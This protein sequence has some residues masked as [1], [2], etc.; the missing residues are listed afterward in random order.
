MRKLFTLSLC[1]VSA[2]ALRAQTTRQEVA[3]NSEYDG[4]TYCSYYGGKTKQTAPPEGYEPFYVSHYGRHGSRYM[5]S[6]KPY[7]VLI[8][9]LEKAQREGVLTRLGVQTLKKLRVAYAHS[10][11]KAGELTALGGRQHEGIAE[12]LYKRCPG[13]FTRTSR[14][15]AASTMVHRAQESMQF[16][17]GRLKHL[18]FDMY[19]QQ[20][21]TREDTTFMRA[22][23][24]KPQTG[25]LQKVI[26]KRIDHVCDSLRRTVGI[27][28]KLFTDATFLARN[29][30]DTTRLAVNFYDVSKDMYCLPELHLRF[31]GLFSKTDLF[32]LWQ[33]T[34]YDWIRSNGFIAGMTP[35]YKRNYNL[36]QDIITKAD[37]KMDEGGT[38]ASLRFGH[39]S[40]LVP[41]AYMLQL[42]GS[43]NF[44]G[45]NDVENLYKYYSQFKV[46][47]MAG[48]IQL[49]FYRKKGSDDV[50][51]KFLLNERESSI[52]IKTDCAPYYHWRDVKAFYEASMKQ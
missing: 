31:K 20:R 41:L 38:G 47:P 13:V 24:L 17:C 36:L 12:R 14:V 39:D 19:I 44:P 26:V 48:N 6:N 22:L 9:L 29:M 33:T 18:N 23:R 32:N 10:T 35:N 8:P 16:F 52:P 15:E 11:G 21:T 3:G 4:G 1:L 43:R 45:L 40:Y 30:K 28:H 42:D 49:I 34:N 2:M 7:H 37:K 5:M 50:L 51:V 27:S 46:T 25:P